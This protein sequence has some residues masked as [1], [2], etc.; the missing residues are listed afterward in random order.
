MVTILTSLTDGTFNDT[1]SAFGYDP[2]KDYHGK[3]TIEVWTGGSTRQPVNAG[4]VGGMDLYNVVGRALFRTCNSPYGKYCDNHSWQTFDTPYLQTP[5][6]GVV[7]SVTYC[8][9]NSSL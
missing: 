2:S 9:C 5:P 4:N 3:A 8:K 7:Q 1:E 6:A